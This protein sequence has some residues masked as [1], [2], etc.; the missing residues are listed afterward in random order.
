LSP[1]ESQIGVR[2]GERYVVL[3]RRNLHYVTKLEESE[4]R[5]LGSDTGI[6]DTL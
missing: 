3:A 2:K 6:T 4:I 1:V 5:M